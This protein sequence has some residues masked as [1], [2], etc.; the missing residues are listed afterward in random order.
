MYDT[1]SSYMDLEQYFTK[2]SIDMLI[3]NGDYT[4]EVI[5]YTKDQG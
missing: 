4:D 3:K 2:L 5:F 1:L